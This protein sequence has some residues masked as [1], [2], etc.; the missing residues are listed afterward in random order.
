MLERRGE[1][2]LAIVAIV[3]GGGAEELARARVRGVTEPRARVA[4]SAGRTEPS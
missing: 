1:A 2:V 3:T 4:T